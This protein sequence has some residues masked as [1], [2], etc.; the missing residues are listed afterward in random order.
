MPDWSEVFVIKTVKNTTPWTHAIS[1]LNSEEIAGMF[2][3]KELQKTNQTKYRTQKVIEKK[4]EKLYV[5]WKSY[6]NSFN[7][8]IDKKDVII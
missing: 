1:D 6:G 7:S 8:W 2:F 5:K 3:E 4:S